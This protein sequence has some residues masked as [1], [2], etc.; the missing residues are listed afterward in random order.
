MGGC[1][2]VD[3]ELGVCCDGPE[4]AVLNPFVA[5]DGRSRPCRVFGSFKAPGAAA[6]V[7][8]LS[9][10]GEGCSALMI[11]LTRPDFL[12]PSSV[13]VDVSVGFSSPS[14]HSG[15]FFLGFDL[16][17]GVV[18]G[19]LSFRFLLG[20]SSPSAASPSTSSCPFVCGTSSF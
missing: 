10:G 20:G 19:S 18:M 1:A 11:W 13:N 7:C 4:L 14:F 6:L 2:A 12:F 3:A 9:G 5:L 15:D 17:F 16:D 8:R